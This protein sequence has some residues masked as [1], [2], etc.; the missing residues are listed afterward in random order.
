M[1]TDFDIVVPALALRDTSEAFDC[2]ATRRY[3]QRAT[4]TWVDYFI[5]SGSTTQGQYLTADE[6]AKVLDLGS[7]LRNRIGFWRVAGN[8]KTSTTP[9][10]ALSHLW[11]S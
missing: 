3:A 6:R 4:S 7:I 2:A 9:R 10:T 5:L 1:T 8:R 11:P